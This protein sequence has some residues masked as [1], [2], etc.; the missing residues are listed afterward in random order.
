MEIIDYV[1]NHTTT[2]VSFLMLIVSG[3]SSL[4]AKA[5][6]EFMKLIN[7]HQIPHLKIYAHRMAILNESRRNEEKYINVV[8]ITNTSSREISY[9]GSIQISSPNLKSDF[10]D[11]TFILNPMGDGCLLLSDTIED[12]FIIKPNETKRYIVWVNDPELL[13]CIDD[14]MHLIYKIDSGKNGMEFISNRVDWKKM[15]RIMLFSG[16]NSY[17]VMLLVS[18]L[19]IYI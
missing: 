6:L 3:C 8:S 16:E 15:N 7:S 14:G 4:T 19:S 12:N 10:K 9:S 18:L 2:I 1:S 5:S 13:S 17:I 11:G